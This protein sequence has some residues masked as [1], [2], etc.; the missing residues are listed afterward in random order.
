[1]YKVTICDDLY[2]CISG[3]YDTHN[4]SFTCNSREEVKQ[5]IGI[6]LSKGFSIGI[7][8]FEEGEHE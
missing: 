4:I 2:G 8:Q 7:K 1:M 3:Q 6:F 5:I